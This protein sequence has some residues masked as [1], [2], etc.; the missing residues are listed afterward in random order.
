MRPFDDEI[1]Y[2]RMG[3]KVRFYPKDSMVSQNV[4]VQFVKHPKDFQDDDE[5]QGSF[6]LDFIYKMINYSVQQLKQEIQGE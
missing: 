1:Y 6:S 3:S 2:W 4:I 5:L